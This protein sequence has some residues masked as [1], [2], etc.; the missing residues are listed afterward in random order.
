MFEYLGDRIGLDRAFGRNPRRFGSSFS[1]SSKKLTSEQ[2]EWTSWLTSRNEKLQCDVVV[3]L[4]HQMYLCQR[5]THFSLHSL[6]PFGVFVVSFHHVCVTS[7]RI[8]AVLG[9][10][11]NSFACS[12]NASRQD[13]SSQ[14][15][16]QAFPLLP[17]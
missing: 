2:F 10:I 14:L 16:K 9:R 4:W 15:Q 5:H 1:E 17:W 12:P 8:A 3:R 6:N 7:P 13:V 11:G